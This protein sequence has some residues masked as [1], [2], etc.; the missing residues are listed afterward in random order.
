MWVFVLTDPEG[1]PGPNHY[2]SLD[3]VCFV[4]VFA[5]LLA[6]LGFL[7]HGVVGSVKQRSSRGRPPPRP[8]RGGLALEAEQSSGTGHGPA[9]PPD[10][11][12]QT[13]ADLRSDSSRPGRMHSSGRNGWAPRGIRSYTSAP[14]V[15]PI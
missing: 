12:D 14:A 7:V 1:H 4:V 9:L 6:A 15:Y 3:G 13:R 10:R 5:A 11:P 2:Q 8:G